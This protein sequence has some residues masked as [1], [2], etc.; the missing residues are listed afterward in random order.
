MHAIQFDADLICRYDRPGPRYTS[1]PTVLQF[2]PAF[3]AAA[4]EARVR[5]AR[6]QGLRSLSLYVH[7]PFCRSPCFYCACNRVI[8]RRREVVDQYLSRLYREIEMQGELFGR[9]G[10]IEQL[11][12]GGGTPTYLESS[13]LGELIG[14]LGRHFN[15]T[16]SGQRE[17]SIEIDPRTVDAG[18]IRA[19][20]DLGINRV[21]L[22]VQDFDPAVQE[23]VNRIQ[24]ET[25][26]IALIEAARAAGMR[27]VSIDLIYGLPRQT[28]AGFERTLRTVIDARPDRLAVY[29]YAHLPRMFKAQR[30]LPAAELP[31]PQLRLQL[32]GLSIETLTAAGYVYVG[33]DHF[34]LPD[35]ELVRA[36]EQG[37]LHRN[38]Q[39]YST[40][41]HCDLVGLGVS[42]IGKIGSAYAQNFR[43]LPDYYAAIDSGRLPIQRGLA[44]SHDDQIRRAV[45]QGLMCNEVV[46]FADLERQFGID[47]RRYFAPELQRLVS[48]E[49]DGLV[50]LAPGS[51]RVTDAGRL[52][53]RNIAMVF[54]AW[55][56]PPESGAHSRAI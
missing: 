9:E 51:I 25:E 10:V 3:D 15:L 6:L 31:S 56:P 21:S 40:R 22:G 39:G 35:D 41:A 13:Q 32:L 2:T 49:R 38:F 14:K 47:F 5:D 36:R 46:T 4:Y 17:Y 7:I 53:M 18:Y 16:D 45:I 23:A 50:Q 12:F 11:H 29:G 44:L 55:L 33:M 48:L 8:T 37:S 1:Y 28:L 26:T 20:A 54:D 42:A 27:S 24:S 30:R 52:L 43:T 34:A 19:L